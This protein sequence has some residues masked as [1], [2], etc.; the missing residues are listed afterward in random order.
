MGL[1]APPVLDY[2]GRKTLRSLADALEKLREL[3]GLSDQEIVKINVWPL[4][5]FDGRRT[6][7][8]SVVRPRRSDGSMFVVLMP[9]SGAFSAALRSETSR[10][11]VPVRR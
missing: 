11:F 5:L 10:P 6:A 3:D 2:D 7:C 8:V 1:F 9:S 4:R